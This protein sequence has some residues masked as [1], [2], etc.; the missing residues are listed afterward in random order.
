M[1]YTLPKNLCP[2][3]EI[4]SH[5]VHFCKGEI[6]FK[7]LAA[8]LRDTRK[9]CRTKRSLSMRQQVISVTSAYK[10]GIGTCI[11]W[12]HKLPYLDTTTACVISSHSR[13]L[14]WGSEI[15]ELRLGLSKAHPIYL[16]LLQ[17]YSK[18]FWGHSKIIEIAVEVA[19][20]DAFY[21]NWLVKR[22]WRAL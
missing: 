4:C 6:F 10:T 9:V 8:R 19:R 12:R 18:C 5:G 21:G 16:H 3:W 15:W 13:S 7:S 1:P 22:W 11:F 14:F 20:F 2:D 17:T